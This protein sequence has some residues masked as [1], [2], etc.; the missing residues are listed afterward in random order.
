MERLVH[1]GPRT[2]SVHWYLNP[3]GRGE[4][5]VIM[6]QGGASSPPGTSEGSVHLIPPEGRGVQ[7]W[8]WQVP[9][10]LVWAGDRKLPRERAVTSSLVR[11][12]AGTSCIQPPRLAAHHHC[13]R[14]IESL[15]HSRTLDYGVTKPPIP[16]PG[17]RDGPLKAECRRGR[18]GHPY[19]HQYLGVR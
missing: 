13:L 8:G 17:V 2:G 1:L 7:H 10:A 18:S 15:S 4:G 5:V 11:P 19:R 16:W 6:V 14:T 12:H 3:H 9:A